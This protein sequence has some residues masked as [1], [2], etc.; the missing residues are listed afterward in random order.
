M[1]FLSNVSTRKVLALCQSFGFCSRPS[2]SFSDSPVCCAVSR[3]CVLA[4]SRWLQVALIDSVQS[5]HFPVWLGTGFSCSVCALLQVLPF[6]SP[7]S[8]PSW[9]DELW[10]SMCLI[11]AE[12]T[13]SKFG[14][15]I[16]IGL[17]NT[18]IAQNTGKILQASHRLKLLSCTEKS[19]EPKCNLSRRFDVTPNVLANVVIASKCKTTHFNYS[20]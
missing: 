10:L 9:N 15:P 12:Q 11:Q 5:T 19:S 13:N 3:L 2:P 4:W 7:K 18:K 8:S 1:L 14:T 20:S 6:A 16:A 17:A